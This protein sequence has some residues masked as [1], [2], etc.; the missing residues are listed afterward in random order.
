MQVSSF[1]IGPHKTP[2]SIKALIWITVLVSLLSPVITF[3]LN[4]YV[5]IPGPSQWLALSEW[6][7]AKKWF[8]QPFTYFFV[9]TAGW[10]IS[11]SFLLSIAF[12]MFL[13]WFTGSEVVF[14]F[15]ARSFLLF[16]LGGGIVVGI[17]SGLALWAFSSTSVILGS[18]PPL[19]AL[20]AVWTM[21]YPELELY[22]FFL[23]KV[24]AK[25]LAIIFLSLTLLFNLSNGQYI[26]CLSDF[27]GILWGFMIGKVVWKLPLPFPLH[28]P[29]IRAKRSSKSG[30]IIDISVFQENDEDFMN[31]MLEKIS[32]KGEGS[33]SRREKERM[34]KI[35][36]KKKHFN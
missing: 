30:K 5:S 35:S 21:L 2:K 27:L 1:F 25:W 15:G 18:G 28:F 7:L 23:I 22:F 32:K 29:L 3:F 31:R 34:K 6:G 4:R 26:V 13:L 14:R 8:W 24:K 19:Y 11:L 12:H 20:V 10:G 36:E 16:Y 33:L 17:L 9:Y